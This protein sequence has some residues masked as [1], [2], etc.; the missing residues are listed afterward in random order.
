MSK[1]FLFLTFFVSVLILSSAA[2]AWESIDDFNYNL[3]FEY[4]VNS[5]LIVCATEDLNNVLGWND[6]EV[7]WATI[8]MECSQS[9]GGE[10]CACKD[11]LFATHG[12]CD[13]TMGQFGQGS[14]QNLIVWQS[15][16]PAYDAA[17]IIQQDY[18]YRVSY[19]SQKWQNPTFKAYLYYGYIPDNNLLNPDVNVIVED[20]PSVTTSWLTYSI[21]FIA[22]PG[23]AYIG[24]PLGIRFF[25]QGGG[26]YWV[27]NVRV[28][29]RPLTKARDPAPA[30]EATGV[31]RSPTL[32]WTAGTYVADVNGHEVYFGTSW[33]EV[34]DANRFD[35]TGIY[36]GN[37]V[38]GPNASD[39][40]SYT[41]PET[42]DL[43]RYCYWRI[44]EVNEAYSGPTPPP[45]DR[46][47][48]DVWS[49]RVTG[50][51]INPSPADG[52]EDVPGY[53]NLSW[54]PGTDSDK[55]DVYFGTDQAAVTD[56]NIDVNFGVYRGRQDANVVNN[57]NLVPVLELS[58]T[59][60][61][62]ID[63]VNEAIG[64]LIRGDVWSFTVAEYL[65]VEDFNSY[66]SDE[67][68]GN[69]WH[70]VYTGGVNAYVYLENGATDANLVRDGNSMKYEYY[71]DASP[72]YS[73]AYANTADLEMANWGPDWTRSNFES[74]ALYFHGKIG[75]D[76]KE[77]MYVAL[78]DGD[79]PKRT[80]MVVY[81][82]SND[83]EQGWKHY[84]EWNINLQEFADDN[85]VNLANIWR[86]TIGFGDGSAPSGSGEGSVYFD[87][88]RL[89][90][91]RCVPEF[92][93][94]TG[95]FRYLNR[96]E[97]EGSFVSDCKNDYFDLWSMG[98]D[99]LMSSYGNATAVSPSTTNLKG[100]WAMDD[101]DAQLQVDDS[102]GN[103]KHGTL[104]DENR[105][106][107]RSTT[108]HSTP[109]KIGTA[110]T[111][112]GVD[113]YVE[114][115]T[116]NLNSNT[117]TISAWIKRDGDLGAWGTYPPIVSCNEPNGFKFCFGSTA[118]YA[119]EMWAANNELAYFWTGWSWD[120]HS[121]LIVP[122]QVWSFVALVVEPDKGTLYLYDG[123]SMR[124]SVN[125]E[126][127]A[128][129]AFSATSYFGVAVKGAIDDVHIYNR[130]LSPGEILGLAGLSGTHY[131]ALEPWRPD[132]NNDDKIDLRDFAVTADNWLEEIL[133]PFE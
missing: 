18:E 70:D 67:E 3:S 129:K 118:T 73:E 13:L 38:V 113:D 107:G 14:D 56:A 131:L 2:Q 42:L 92:A 130:A 103:L 15:L 50:S 36:R 47:K 122:N 19:D 97:A 44:D 45:D 12:I 72:Y 27:D 101:K 115:P 66:A 29:C 71:D 128:V 106:P 23:A 100:Y 108:K 80:A 117:V 86:I 77:R 52:A 35:E 102:S 120:A 63:E 112:D 126:D 124:S 75:N 10:D 54:T 82:D 132:A 57:S 119:E 84:Q 85:N 91:A 11:G 28:E 83:I 9:A 24:E 68:L 61:W 46:W 110:L 58:K 104:Y 30:D 94:L 48:G 127:H 31:S 64:S 116:L 25:E 96:Y 76:A 43:G 20:E 4:D 5:N 34:N 26:W 125:Y 17:A 79:N 41:I 37:T 111:F 65:A 90:P 81:H 99:W 1:K 95:S 33:D 123:L 88:I 59:Y 8:E 55:H 69:V 60:Y 98:S 7:N 32:S 6:N 51:A 105:S 89:Y 39:R 133:W 40:Y 87:D 109:G 21:G 22:V 74:L 93:H 53:T 114:I 49:F 78:T 16:D 121:G 62:R